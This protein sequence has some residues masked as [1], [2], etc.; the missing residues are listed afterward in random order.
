MAKRRPRSQYMCRSPRREGPE[1]ADKIS[2]L[3]SKTKTLSARQTGSRII[4]EFG[5]ERFRLFRS[6]FPYSCE[7]YRSGIEN[8]YSKRGVSSWMLDHVEAERQFDHTLE[9]PQVGTQKSAVLS[10]DRQPRRNS[11][12]NAKGA[13]YRPP[14]EERSL[15]RNLP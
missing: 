5:S 2:W 8:A 12:I 1:S 10:R 14:I 13:S 3:S 4:R 11:N 9:S 6:E 15:E 7:F